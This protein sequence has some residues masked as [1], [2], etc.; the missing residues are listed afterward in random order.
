MGFTL[1][2][3]EKS[4]VSRLANSI[5]QLSGSELRCC[6]WNGWRM[7]MLPEYQGHSPKANAEL[8]LKVT[9]AST[10]A[11]QQESNLLAV[12]ERNLLQHGLRSWQLTSMRCAIDLQ[13]P[14]RPV[15]WQTVSNSNGS[16]ITSLQKAHSFPLNGKMPIAN[17]TF[18]ESIHS[19]QKF[20]NTM[21]RHLAFN[22]SLEASCLVKKT[23]GR[24]HAGGNKD[25]W[26]H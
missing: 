8:S 7:C 19:C 10:V 6:L 22:I 3:N 9:V 26:H 4:P 23:D 11:S 1:K 15:N 24:N 2:K 12:S 5:H 21:E 20:S 14:K 18:A 25:M 16:I 13:H 17:A